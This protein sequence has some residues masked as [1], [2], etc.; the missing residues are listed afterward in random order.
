VNVS[1]QADV[2]SEIPAIVVGIFVDDNIVPVPQPAATVI[3]I[4]RRDAEVEAA[5]P[6]ATGTTSGKTPTVTATE[7]AGE[8]AMLPGVIEVE[9]GIIASGVVSNPLAVVVDVRGLG[10]AFF[11]AT[12]RSGRRTM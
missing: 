1:A 8:T 5:K 10:M 7:A 2:I 6:E 9:A 4:K 11:I 12:S 3:Q